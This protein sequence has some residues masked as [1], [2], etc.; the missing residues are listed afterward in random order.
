MLFSTYAKPKSLLGII[1]LSMAVA[2][3]VLDEPVWS[4]CANHME[5][6]PPR[7]LLYSKPPRTVVLKVQWAEASPGE[8]IKN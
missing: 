4:Y 7:A 6:F 8:L 3:P 2:D 5:E 1:E